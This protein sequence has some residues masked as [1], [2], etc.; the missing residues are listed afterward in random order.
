MV[1]TN[2]LAEWTEVFNNTKGDMTVY[3]DFGTIKKKGHKVKMWDLYDF[4]TV[5]NSSKGGFFSQV[6]LD[7][8]D[9]EEETSRI[10]TFYNYSGNMRSGDIVYSDTDT[11]TVKSEPILPDSINQGLFKIACGKK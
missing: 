6:G 1:S 4:K 2:V 9:C 10:L 7:E 3:V 11:D 8:F 5:K